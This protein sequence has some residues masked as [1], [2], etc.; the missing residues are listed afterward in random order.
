MGKVCAALAKIHRVQ[1]DHPLDLV[2]S[3]S[4]EDICAI[5]L[6]LFHVYL[7]GTTH[8]AEIAVALARMA[9]LSERCDSARHRDALYASGPS[10]H[11]HGDVAP[12]NVITDQQGDAV[13]FDFNNAYFGSR[14]ADVLDGAFEFSLAEQYIHLADFARFDAFLSR[15]AASNPLTAKETKK[16]SQWIELV[17]FIKFTREIRALLEHPTDGLRRKRALAIAEFVLSRTAAH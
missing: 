11:N 5:W 14:M 15:Y 13:F 2:K 4:F 3:F 17:G 1:T 6:P 7:S 12:K 16:L 8:D 9:P 10:V